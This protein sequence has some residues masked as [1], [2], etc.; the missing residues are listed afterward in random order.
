[1]WSEAA[2]GAMISQFFRVGE[3]MAQY[4]RAL[5]AVAELLASRI[6]VRLFT[7]CL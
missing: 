4:L 3:I 7:N 1:M 6:Q 2:M 5:V